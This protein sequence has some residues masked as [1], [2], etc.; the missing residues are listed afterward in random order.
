MRAC[1]G[2][3][4]IVLLDCCHQGID[5]GRGPLFFRSVLFTSSSVFDDLGNDQKFPRH[6]VCVCVF[7]V[8]CAFVCVCVPVRVCV[9]LACAC[10]CLCVYLTC[11]CASVCLCM[12]VVVCFLSHVSVFECVFRLSVCVEH[13]P[14]REESRRYRSLNPTEVFCMASVRAK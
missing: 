8:V 14:P 12:R 4:K 3:R 10:V 5:T 13:R 6:P 1:K 9:Y 11:V 2:R 7:L